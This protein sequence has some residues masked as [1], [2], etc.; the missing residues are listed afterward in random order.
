MQDAGHATCHMQ[1]QVAP[2]CVS[3]SAAEAA[4]R[5]HLGVLGGLAWVI[6]MPGSGTKPAGMSNTMA[7]AYLHLPIHLYPFSGFSELYTCKEEERGGR[8]CQWLIVIGWTNA[9]DKVGFTTFSVSSNTTMLC[10]REGSLCCLHFC[11]PSFLAIQFHF[12]ITRVVCS[13]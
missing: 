13:G 4:G 1:M 8:I 5:F 2:C 10:H 11:L 7:Q 12:Q 3:Q 6:E 9:L